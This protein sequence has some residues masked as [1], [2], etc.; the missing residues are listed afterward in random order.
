MSIDQVAGLGLL[1][2][3]MVGSVWWL[4]RG[5]ARNAREVERAATILPVLA[6]GLGGSFER[7]EHGGWVYGYAKLGRITGSTPALSYEISCHTRHVGDADF[8]WGRLYCF[9]RP[10]AKDQVFDLP[11]QG[12]VW[13][14]GRRRPD[15]VRAAFG[16]VYAQ[17]VPAGLHPALLRLVQTSDHVV[18]V[19]DGIIACAPAE[20]FD[21]YDR[22]DCDAG[23]EW[24]N[25]L[26]ACQRRV[27]LD[28]LSPVEN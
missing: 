8:L 25:A 10:A 26:L 12:D 1:A 6:H 3:I 7:V 13:R 27:N 9:V 21:W 28:P 19:P 5:H 24:V 18:V 14:R 2:L 11:R 16:S 15:S 20:V 22:L 17:A 4:V 23:A